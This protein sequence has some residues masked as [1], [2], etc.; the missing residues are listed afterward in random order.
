MTSADIAAILARIGEG[1]RTAAPSIRGTWGTVL[2]GVGA[3]LSLVGDL[4]A[5]NRDPVVHIDAIRDLDPDLAKL[6]AD[7]ERARQETVAAHAKP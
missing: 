2:G 1:A 6:R 4:I 3:G 7:R 5:L